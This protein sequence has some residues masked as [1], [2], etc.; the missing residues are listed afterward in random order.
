MRYISLKKTSKNA[1]ND[2][3]GALPLPESFSRAVFCSGRSRMV[4]RCALGP[5]DTSSALVPGHGRVRRRIIVRRGAS[6]PC[7]VLDGT[8]A[9]PVTTCVRPVQKTGPEKL[10]GSGRALIRY[11]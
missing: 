2:I 8:G 10:S 11:L 7:K 9:L 3:R 6:A 5:S 1:C 4:L